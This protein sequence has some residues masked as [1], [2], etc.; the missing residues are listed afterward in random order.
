M[1]WRIP[2]PALG[3]NKMGGVPEMRPGKL[4]DANGMR[5]GKQNC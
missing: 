4:F 1:I 3:R 2:F 5:S